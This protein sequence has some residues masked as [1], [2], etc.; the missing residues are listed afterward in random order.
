MSPFCTIDHKLS[1]CPFR[2]CVDDPSDDSMEN[3]SFALYPSMVDANDFVLVCPLFVV[4]LDYQYGISIHDSSAGILVLIAFA[5]SNRPTV[6]PRQ[7]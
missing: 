6:K 5:L 1:V 2:I 3:V 7:T 4:L